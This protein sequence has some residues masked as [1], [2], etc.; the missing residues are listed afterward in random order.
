MATRNPLSCTATGIS[1]TTRRPPERSPRRTES[2]KGCRRGSTCQG[3]SPGTSAGRAACRREGCCSPA[4]RETRPWRRPC[5]ASREGAPPAS[6]R[7][8]AGDWCGGGTWLVSF[9]PVSAAHVRT[10]KGVNWKQKETRKS[11]L[12]SYW[13]NT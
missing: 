11:K 4:G 2:T 10:L 13:Y 7:H 9:V 1:A 6:R 5:V 8:L 3:C 12:Q